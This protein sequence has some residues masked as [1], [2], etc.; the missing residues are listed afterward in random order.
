M[1]LSSYFNVIGTF[2][3]A[4]SN[5][6][7]SNCLSHKSPA[8]WSPYR[9]RSRGTTSSSIYAHDFGHLCFGIRIH[10]SGHS[11]FGFFILNVFWDRGR[12]CGDRSVLS[13]RTVLHTHLARFCSA[14]IE[15]CISHLKCFLFAH[16]PPRCTSMSLDL[17]LAK[18]L[19][20]FA[21]PEAFRTKLLDWL[22]PFWLKPGSYFAFRF[23]CTHTLPPLIPRDQRTA[24]TATLA[25]PE[26]V[27]K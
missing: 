22:K 12:V 15:F 23:L 6:A 11:D 7:F 3:K 26:T 13:R 1:F 2:S 27:S 20:E 4:S 19:D 5:N 14:W 8:S 25:C 16:L 17:E 24:S 10:T 9:F 18:I 21:V